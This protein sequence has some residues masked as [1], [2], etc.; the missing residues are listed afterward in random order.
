M[1][2]SFEN[3]IIR[4]ETYIERTTREEIV[5]YDASF[6]FPEV[7]DEAE[8][9]VKEVKEIIK[10]IVKKEVKE[11]VEEVKRIEEANI[12][13]KQEVKEKVK[14]KVKGTVEWIKEEVKEA[15]KEAVKEAIE[16]V[17]E[18]TKEEVEEEVEEEIEEAVEEGIEEA[19]EE[20]YFLPDIPVTNQDLYLEEWSNFLD[21]INFQISFSVNFN[22]LLNWYLVCNL[23]F[24]F[25]ML[26]FKMPNFLMPWFSIPKARYGE[27]CYGESVYGPPEV[28]YKALQRALHELKFTYLAYR[29]NYNIRGKALK[30]RIEW[31]KDFLIKKGVKPEYVDAMI[32]TVHTVVGKV[33]HTS[34]VGFATVNLNKVCKTAEDLGR[35]VGIYGVLS[36]EDFKSEH[37]IK[38]FLPYDNVVGMVRVDYCRVTPM[39]ETIR[40]S[41]LRPLAQDFKKRVTEFKERSGMMPIRKGLDVEVRPE[42]KEITKHIE[43]PTH[44]F[45]PRVFLLNPERNYRIKW[46]GGKHQ[47]RLQNLIEEVKDVLNREGVA[48]VLRVAYIYFAHEY[49]YMHYTKASRRYKQWRQMMNE[50]DIIDKYKRMGLDEK[51]L[52]KII[53]KIRRIKVVNDIESRA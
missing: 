29:P 45:Y 39:P 8:I 44:V 11:V 34:Y 41:H 37:G 43:P 24:D 49:A 38:T 12:Q 4:K 15:G 31:L 53:E 46:E 40:D 21:Q 27:T 3:I 52:R 48:G 16:E 23:H 51:I 20:T 9:V 28:T 32:R 26:D 6:F 35:N 30:K 36:T 7:I 50:E 10:E 5:S 47:A 19:F 42:I 2:I 13:V 33:I 22:F 14:E 1:P 18:E 25:S 17:E